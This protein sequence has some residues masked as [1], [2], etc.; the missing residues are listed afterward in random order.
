[1]GARLLGG[2]EAAGWI[3]RLCAMMTFSYFGTHL[4]DMRRKRKQ[5]GQTWFQYV[6][7]PESML[8]NRRDWREF[9]GSIKWFVGKGPR[10]EYGRWTYWEKFDYTWIMHENP[11]RR[12][13]N[14]SSGAAAGR[15][16]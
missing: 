11:T 1:V 7:G 10:P 3:H 4:W 8:M 14:V 15:L 5:S 12:T 16:I 9:V 2:F 13:G 6:T